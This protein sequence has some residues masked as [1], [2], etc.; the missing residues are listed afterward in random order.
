MYLQYHFMQN[1][2]LGF[3]KDQIIVTSINDNVIKNRDAFTN[4]L[5][6][7]AGVDNVTYGQ[8]LLSSRD[9]YMGWGRAYHDEEINFQCLPVEPSFF[10]VMG[11]TITE[12]RGFRPEDA[13]TRYGAYVF[14]EKAR[15]SY[16]L[17]LNDRID[18]AEIIGFMPDVK[19]A[20]LRQEVT[21]MAFFVWG[22]QNWG[23][24]YNQT[25][26]RIKAGTDMRAAIAH[27]RTTLK[28]FD[29]EYPFNVRFYDGVL[30]RTYEKE[31][32][33]STLISLFSLVAILI[34]IV[35]VFGLVVFDSEYRRK[36]ISLR[37]V[38]G[39]TTGE[40]LLLFNKTYLRILV[41]C[42]VVA[43]PVA[44]YAVSRWLENFAYRTPL[45]WWVYL[46]AFVLVALLT[47]CTVTFQNWRAANANPV[48]G[49]KTE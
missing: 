23:T 20:S 37:K 21:P 48:E 7:F 1:T 45:Y 4:R 32:N 30:Q 38:F 8:F 36:E 46:T 19:F 2:P 39:S 34:S 17:K 40:I 42:F 29:D 3:E 11:I 28:A 22:T 14:N 6:N 15:S 9:T 41:L 43:A 27:V 35:G 18:S 33:F 5:K 26:I 12:G 24:T 16:D 13:L 47:I 10:E 44:W 49:I 31:R 25:Y